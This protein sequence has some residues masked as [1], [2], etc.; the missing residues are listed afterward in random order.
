MA[1][2][3]CPPE[4]MEGHFRRTIETDIQQGNPDSARCVALH[5]LMAPCPLAHAAGCTGIAKDGDAPRQGN[6]PT[7]G[8]TAQQEIDAGMGGLTVDLGGVGEQDGEGIRRN[9]SQGLF[10]IVH[11]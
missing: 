5:A 6:L 9:R 11:A 3:S 10:Q 1:L 7:M 2:G 4:Y 8:M